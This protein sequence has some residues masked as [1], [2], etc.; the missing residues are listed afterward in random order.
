VCEGEGLTAGDLLGFSDP[1]PGGPGGTENMVELAKSRH[2]KTV[3]L[4]A[5]ELV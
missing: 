2:V 4:P 5:L 3:Q 1:G